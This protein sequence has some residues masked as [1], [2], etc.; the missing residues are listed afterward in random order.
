MS[1]IQRAITDELF[2][3]IKKIRR[4]QKGPENILRIEFRGDKKVQAVKIQAVKAEFEYLRMCE[5][6]ILDDYFVRFFEIV[7]NSK[8]LGKDVPKK[9]N[10]EKAVNEFK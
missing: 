6:E 10:C 1:L 3:C 9:M 4:L 5:G 2:P 7:N 8:S